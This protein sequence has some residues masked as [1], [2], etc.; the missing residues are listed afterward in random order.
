M[1]INFL[2]YFS[3]GRFTSSVVNH[4]S[5][6]TKKPFVP[7]ILGGQELHAFGHLE[8]KTEQV[9]KG[10]GLQVLCLIAQV[11]IGFWIWR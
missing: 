7:H 6:E 3:T 10:Q 9:V 1:S 11:F 5:K 2:Q 4:Q 8:G